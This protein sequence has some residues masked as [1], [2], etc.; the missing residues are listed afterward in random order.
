[1]IL[2]YHSL[3]ITKNDLIIIQQSSKDNLQISIRDKG[4]KSYLKDE[5]FI[6]KFNDSD[7]L[8]Y[9]IEKLRIE[10]EKIRQH[11]KY[12]GKKTTIRNKMDSLRLKAILIDKELNKISQKINR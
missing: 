11:A 3:K 12:H 8:D 6:I 7:T 2:D 4:P 1:M 10:R 5:C 9:F